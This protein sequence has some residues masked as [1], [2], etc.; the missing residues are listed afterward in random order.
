MQA[1]P[2]YDLR[3]RTPRLE[4][5]LPDLDLLDQLIALAVRG[6]HPP[7]TMP[8]GV[9]WTDLP[10]PHMERESLQH[11]LLQ[12]AQWRPE[13]WTYNPVVLYRGEVA[14]TQDMRAENFSASRMF[15]TGSWLGMEFQGMGLGTEMRAAILHLGFA[16]LGAQEAQSSAFSDNLASLGVSRALGYEENGTWRAARRGRSGTMIGLRLSLGGWQSH[17]FHE[18]TIEGLDPCL[19][20]F[21]VTPEK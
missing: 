4:L 1:W 10:S 12:V 11:H 21:G 3:L 2:L 7:E 6:V 18:V 15:S 9:P 17:H 13:K 5:R 16:G 19:E 20:L 14:G 8:F